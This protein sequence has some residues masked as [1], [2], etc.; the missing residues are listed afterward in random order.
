MDGRIFAVG[1]SEYTQQRIYATGGGG[2]VLKSTESLQP[3]MAAGARWVA[4]PEMEW[5]RNFLSLVAMHD[6]L[7]AIGGHDQAKIPLAFVESLDP[8]TDDAWRSEARLREARARLAAV[9]VRGSGI[10]AMGGVDILHHATETVEFY[11]PHA[12][13]R[14]TPSSRPGARR[15]ED[16]H[17]AQAG[18]DWG[19]AMSLPAPRVHAAAVALE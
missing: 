8:L 13:R 18:A 19:Y 3:A 6:R 17:G 5:P 9:C 15:E 2:C 11:S 12:G 7:W 14:S 10:L 1:G 16:E 4:G